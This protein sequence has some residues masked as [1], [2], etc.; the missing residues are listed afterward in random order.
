M[1]FFKKMFE[2]NT[3]IVFSYNDTYDFSLTKNG[4]S[5]FVEVKIFINKNS[6]RS[7]K[8]EL[9]TINSDDLLL[10]F[11]AV[12][13]RDDVKKLILD[14]NP[15]VKFFDSRVFKNSREAN[16]MKNFIQSYLEN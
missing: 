5:I 14:I 6:L 7:I 10:I 11:T 8:K 12:E 1:N 9:S 2:K 15:N 3:S 13:V 4:K 16:H